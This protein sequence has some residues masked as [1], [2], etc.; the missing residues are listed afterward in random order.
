M[1]LSVE[2]GNNADPHGACFTIKIPEALIIT[3]PID[4]DIP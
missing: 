4:K 2:A 3:T 1:G